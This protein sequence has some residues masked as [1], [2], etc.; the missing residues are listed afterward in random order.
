L[1]VAQLYNAPAPNEI[2]NYNCGR[3]ITIFNVF[4]TARH[5][6]IAQHY[7]MIHISN[8]KYGAMFVYQQEQKV[9]ASGTRQP[10]NGYPTIILVTKVVKLDMISPKEQTS[11]NQ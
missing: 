4:P 6:R 7:Y 5:W 1:Y 9:A 8:I 2:G 11:D 10:R 3:H